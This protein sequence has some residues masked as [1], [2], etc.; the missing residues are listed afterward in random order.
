M[1]PYCWQS[2]DCR[3]TISQSRLSYTTHVSVPALPPLPPRSATEIVDGAVQLIRPQFG[4]FV[5]I[6][7][8]GAIPALVS[9]VVSLLL[10]QGSP[11]DLTT[12]LRRQT[13]IIP[14]LMTLLVYVFAAMQS[15]AIVTGALAVLRG[16]VPPS[17]WTAFMSAFRRLHAIVGAYVLLI[18]MFVVALLP[19]FLVIGLVSVA[20]GT[21]VAAT[22]RSG[23][24]AVI[25][26]ALLAILALTI[27]V[28]IAATLFA[29][30]V[31][32]TTLVVAERLG[33]FAAL[34][35]AQKLSRGN[36]ALLAKTYGLVLLIMLLITSVMVA[37]SLSFLEQ[38]QLVQSMFSVL[39]IPVA[40]IV[41]SIGL[42]S[43]ADLRVR[44]EGADLDAS[45]DA[46]TAV[47]V[48]QL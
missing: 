32:M 38:Q 31:L 29:Q 25:A 3:R 10:N 11:A 16:D 6:A 37:L 35:R 26:A 44:R 24:G 41:G 43:Y 2:T 42:V 20:L 30:S 40:P 15:G 34:R 12:M 23:T 45:L 17:V 46:L 18:V 8:I 47:P 4:Y 33:P 1:L 22:A 9:S 39:F 21:G 36:Y 7:A 5:R 19:V 27:V 14:L 13:E 48:P 28:L